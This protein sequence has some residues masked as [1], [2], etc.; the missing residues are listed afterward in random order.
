MR[1]AFLTIDEVLE[2]HRDQITRYGGLAGVRDIGLLKSALAQPEST[3]DGQ[4]LHIGLFEMA[5]SYMFHLVQ[6]H[7]FHDGNKRVG[8]ATA[9]V[10]LL[11][12]ECDIRATNKE[13]V[14]LVLDV[15]QSK[16]G[17][18]RIAAFLREHVI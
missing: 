17:K 16:A 9:L 2:I 14:A 8:A 13:L 3:F 12:N 1:P 6:N 15:A 7:P 5:A 10:F 4:F 11:L 18:D